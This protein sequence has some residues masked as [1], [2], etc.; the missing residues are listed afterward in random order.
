MADTRP[1]EARWPE[2][3]TAKRLPANAGVG[4][5]V[6]RAILTTGTYQIPANASDTFA[7]SASAQISVLRRLGYAIDVVDGFYTCTNPEHEPTPEQFAA[8]RAGHRADKQAKR[9]QANGS[10]RPMNG[11]VAKPRRSVLSDVLPPLGAN[12]V[13][14]LVGFG[15]DGRPTLVVSDAV[16]N[17]FTCTVDSID[18]ADATTT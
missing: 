5:R 8:H 1:L 9:A 13:V 4:D 18:A 14:A 16:G 7:A 6:R 10:P 3:R 17:R 15:R 11:R 12:L 2:Y